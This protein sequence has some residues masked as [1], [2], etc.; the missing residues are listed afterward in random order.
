MACPPNPRSIGMHPDRLKNLVT[1]GR[2]ECRLS[3]HLHKADAA[4]PGGG[5]IHV[6]TKRRD[7]NAMK[8]SLNLN[9][10]VAVSLKYANGSI[11][12]ILYLSNGDKSLAKE[13]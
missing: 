4:N 5:K 3:F 1:A 6:I 13:P 10:V 7:A 12:S 9:D 11:G 8:D 2:L